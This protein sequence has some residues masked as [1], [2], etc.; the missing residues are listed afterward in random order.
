MKSIQVSPFFTILTF[1]STVSLPTPI[2][3][4]IS[5]LITWTFIK[6]VVPLSPTG[7]PAVTTTNS[8]WFIYSDSLA[9]FIE[10]SIT[11]SVFS[12]FDE[13]TE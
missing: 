9:A 8:P 7:T 5:S 12:A 2:P 10:Y 4:D 11:S 1:P 13:C 3:V 6:L